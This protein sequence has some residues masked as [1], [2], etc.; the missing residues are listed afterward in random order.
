MRV[1][2]VG[3]GSAG[4]V[5]ARRLT[6]DPSCEVTLMET[7]GDVDTHDPPDIMRSANPWQII[8]GAGSEPFRFPA[9]LSRRAAGQQPKVYWRGRGL[10][11]SSSVNGMQT[12][13]GAP[14][15]HFLPCHSFSHTILKV[16]VRNRHSR[17]FRR[18]VGA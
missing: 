12:I 7:G 14:H 6:E 3:G 18:P 8:A 4:C 17:G 1:L 10:G 15:Q 11:G 5:L 2:I 13:R 9:L 16:L